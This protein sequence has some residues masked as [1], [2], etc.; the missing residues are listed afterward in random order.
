M[1]RS[2]LCIGCEFGENG[3]EPGFCRK[4]E[5]VYVSH[6]TIKD[7]AVRLI[8]QNYLSRLKMS[9]EEIIDFVIHKI[10][11]FPGRYKNEMG[12]FVPVPGYSCLLH[13]GTRWWL[14]DQLSGGPWKSV[15]DVVA[16]H[17]SAVLRWRIIATTI[18]IAEMVL[19]VCR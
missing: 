13:P 17:P 6:E 14:N 12:E 15:A 11:D 3:A 19:P 16:L 7:A 10:R 8:C 2:R 9:N 4:V 18:Q 1:P 5:A